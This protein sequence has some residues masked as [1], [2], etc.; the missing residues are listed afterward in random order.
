MSWALKDGPVKVLKV[1]NTRK[2]H[3][4][5]KEE[6]EQLHGDKKGNDVCKELYL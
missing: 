3:F 6:L 4:M 1:V 2:S 5:Q